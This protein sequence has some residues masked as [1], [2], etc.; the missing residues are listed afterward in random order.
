MLAPPRHAVACPSPC[1][2]TNSPGSA[3]T[4]TLRS[5]ATGIIVAV[6]NA[7]TLP[8]SA[9]S[10]NNQGVEFP[11]YCAACREYE[12]AGTKMG[13]TAIMNQV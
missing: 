3:P 7:T 9:R 8:A 11:Y 13:S 10:P 12:W 4:P 1:S 6:M 2:P 5:A